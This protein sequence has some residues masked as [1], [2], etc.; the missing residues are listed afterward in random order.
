MELGDW[1][2]TPDNGIGY[3]TFWSVRRQTVQ[4]T[5]SYSKNKAYLE[6]QVLPLGITLANEDIYSLQQLAVDTHDRE[7]FES[8]SKLLT[9]SK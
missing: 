7:W 2:Q 4:V 6:H 5:F 1:V 9:G 3:I 8:L